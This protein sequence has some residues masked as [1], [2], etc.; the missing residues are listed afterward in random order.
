MFLFKYKLLQNVNY[1]LVLIA[2]FMGSD[3]KLYD[4]VVK[5][6]KYFAV[7]IAYKLAEFSWCLKFLSLFE[8]TQYRYITSFKNVHW[9]R[10]KPKMNR[11]TNSKPSMRELKFHT[12]PLSWVWLLWLISRQKKY[13]HMQYDALYRQ[14]DTLQVTVDKALQLTWDV[15][16]LKSNPNA[17]S[18]QHFHYQFQSI[19]NVIISYVDL[20]KCSFKKNNYL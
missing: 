9:V 2:P 15:S 17:S 7:D 20:S 3:S 6:R 4:G 16:E 14:Y 10:L 8:S 1:F 12:T 18:S 5:T 11:K 19:E 13:V